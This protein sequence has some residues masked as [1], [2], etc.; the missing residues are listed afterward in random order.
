VNLGC[1]ACHSANFRTND[2][3]EP[4]KSVG[5]MG[6]GN[7]LQ[8]E[9]G[10][11]VHSANLTPDASGLAQWSESDFTRAVLTGIRPDHTVLSYPMFRYRN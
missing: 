7:A 10:Q 2:E 6:G 1:F 8:D 5:Y 11:I 4:E 3:L 9:S